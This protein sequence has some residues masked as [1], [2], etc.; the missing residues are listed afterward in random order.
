M[1]LAI[2]NERESNLNL[3]SESTRK[4]LATA[5]K[6]SPPVTSLIPVD[7]R[8]RQLS[9][10]NAYRTVRPATVDDFH[11]FLVSLPPGPTGNYWALISAL[12]S[13]QCRDKVALAAARRFM[14][15]HPGGAEEVATLSHDQILR[16]CKSC[17]FCQTKAKNILSV[18]AEIT[19][20]S[21]NGLVPQ[22]YEEL[23]S[24]RGVGPKI[25]HLLR[26]VSFGL[27]STGIVVDTHVHRIATTLGW[28]EGGTS[29][30]EEPRVALEKWV[31]SGEWTKFTLGG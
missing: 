22:S 9:L 1:V 4:R 31:P 8:L 15:D 19:G 25:A 28:V 6:S 24:L 7:S 29:T 14:R 18:T 21:Y 26:S 11:A 12:L 10:I 2:Q 5:V 20:P 30:R 17:N 3:N 16:Y 23:L 13:V 27:D